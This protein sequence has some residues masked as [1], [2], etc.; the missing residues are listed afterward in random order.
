MYFTT[1]SEY[2]SRNQGWLLPTTPHERLVREM[3]PI[4]WEH[5]FRS[6]ISFH[7]SYPGTSPPFQGIFLIFSL[8]LLVSP[9]CDSF[10]GTSFLSKENSLQS[11]IKLWLHSCP[12]LALSSRL[13]SAVFNPVHLPVNKIYISFRPFL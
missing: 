3:V 5:I 2:C 11:Q 7:P 10:C 8:H 1:C 12:A 4:P 13:D 6:I 9:V